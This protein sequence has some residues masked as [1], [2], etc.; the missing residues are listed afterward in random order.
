VSTQRPWEVRIRDPLSEVTRKERTLLLGTAA[1]GIGI[2]HTGLVPEKISTL[3]VDFTPA[4]QRAVVAL[5]GFLV[6]YFVVAFLIYAGSDFMAW[7]LAFHSAMIESA[8]E[9][10]LQDQDRR[11]A[12]QAAIARY[13]NRWVAWSRASRP[14]SLLRAMFDLGLPLVIGL[15]A[16][17]LLFGYHP[18]PPATPR[19][20]AI[21]NSTAPNPSLQ[22]TLPGPSPG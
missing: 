2:V 15:Y 21:E 18:A 8:R 14:T 10:A 3:G 5:L 9:R 11:E 1:L 13:R 17:A 7:R 22:R 6:L 4:D 12:E 19:P 16:I 20:A